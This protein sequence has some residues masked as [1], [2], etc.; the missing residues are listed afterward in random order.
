MVLAVYIPPQAP[1]PGQAWC[2]TFL[3]SHSFIFPADFSPQA[4]KAETISSFLSPNFPE[5]IVP[6]YTITEGLSNRNMA[7]NAP[8]MFLSQPTTVTSAS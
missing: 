4:S 2:I 8:G 6:P 5:A 7:I 1:G 3:N